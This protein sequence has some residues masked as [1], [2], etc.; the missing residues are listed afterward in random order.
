MLHKLGF[1][2][3]MTAGT[4]TSGEVAEAC[5]D[6]V[7]ACWCL[8]RHRSQD[9]TWGG[10][11]HPSMMMDA[12]H[13]CVWNA[14]C[15]SLAGHRAEERS[16]QWVLK[17]DG[18]SG[19]DLRRSQPPLGAKSSCSRLR[20]LLGS[21][22]LPRSMYYEAFSSKTCFPNSSGSSPDKRGMQGQSCCTESGESGTLLHAGLSHPLLL[23]HT[24]SPEE[25]IYSAL[26]DFSEAVV[27]A[28]IYGGLSYRGITSH[29]HA[30]C[31][32][33]GFLC[34]PALVG[35]FYLP[36]KSQVREGF[37]TDGMT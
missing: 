19:A 36:L 16:L 2:V 5:G 12:L 30:A 15:S 21:C 11:Q 20:A 28:T 22:I 35:D 32:E 14:A 25:Q 37:D 33:P 23:R 26:N 6:G 27:W 10:K 1:S 17:L 13:L 34:V 3:T 8:K 31:G 18:V 24:S 29:S 9:G 4:S 7:A